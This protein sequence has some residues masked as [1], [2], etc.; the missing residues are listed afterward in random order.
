MEKFPSRLL[1]REVPIA[2]HAPDAAPLAAW[3]AA[4]PGWRPRLVL[5]LPGAWDG[6]EDLL[7]QG[8]YADLA[9]RE[10]A[11]ELP[12]SYWVAPTH[13]KSWYADSRDGSL[14]YERFLVE[15][16]LPALGQRFPDAGARTVAGLSMGGFGALNL[17]AR[18][19]LF[20][21]CVALSPALVEPPFKRAG[22]LLR[23]SLR[24]AFPD[25]K[26]AFAPWDPWVHLGG[27]T[28]LVL[29]CGREDKYGLAELV[30]EFSA[31]CAKRQRPVQLFLRPG[32]HAWSYWTPEFE[33]LAPWIAGGALPPAPP[34]QQAPQAAH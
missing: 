13:Y 17:A 14:P 6:P 31:L 22:W 23:G 25:D 30:E 7:K 21:R 19:R 33:R 16:L 24:R 26:E 27:D 18:T 12:P 11:G 20:D 5:F 10:A 32:D 15:E 4:H 1:K 28:E 9:K 29:G 3:R 2:V 34:A 8:L